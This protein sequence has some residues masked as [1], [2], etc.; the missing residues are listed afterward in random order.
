[1]SGKLTCPLTVKMK[2]PVR[3]TELLHR[4]ARIWMGLLLT[5]ALICFWTSRTMFSGC[6]ARTPASAAWSMRPPSSALSPQCSRVGSWPGS[7]GQ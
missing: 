7:L 6:W 5:W 1:M 2:F 3:L 4:P